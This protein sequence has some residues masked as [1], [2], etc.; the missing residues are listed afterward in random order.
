MSLCNCNSIKG[1]KVPGDRQCVEWKYWPWL[2]YCCPLL[3]YE[4]RCPRYVHT[5]VFKGKNTD[6]QTMI[7]LDLAGKIIRSGARHNKFQQCS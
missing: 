1:N 7:D 5:I 4:G 6:T 2:K 3:Y